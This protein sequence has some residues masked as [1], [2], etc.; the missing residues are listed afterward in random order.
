MLLAGPVDADD[1]DQLDLGGLARA[2]NEDLVRGRVGRQGGASFLAV[3]CFRQRLVRRRKSSA[4]R[5]VS[6][7]SVEG[8]GA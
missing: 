3:W 6:R 2:G 1:Q 8:S 5:P 4:P 7:T